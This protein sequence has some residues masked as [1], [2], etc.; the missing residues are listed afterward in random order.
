MNNGFIVLYRSLIDWE[1]YSDANTFRLFIHCL[2]RANHK[3]KKWQ[4]ITIERGSFVTSY[5]HLA[6]EL[7]LTVQNVRTSMGKL[8]S[9]GELTHKSHTKYGIITINNYYKYQDTNSQTNTQINNQLTINQQSTNNKQQGNKE[10][11]KQITDKRERYGDHVQ[12]T[13]EQYDKLLIDY[14][15]PLVTSMIDRM[16]EYIGIKGGLYK[17]YNLALR[18]WIR[19]ETSKNPKWLAELKQEQQRHDEKVFEAKRDA[20]TVKDLF[21]KL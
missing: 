19:E 4:G 3:E 2:L 13:Q 18:K 12:L 11:K 17:D 1:W 21:N 14:G 20:N 10:T 15:K 6:S 5:A 7:G 16:N 8:K 9:T